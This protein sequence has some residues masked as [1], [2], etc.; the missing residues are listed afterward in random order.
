LLDLPWIA[1]YCFGSSKS[2]IYTNQM[3]LP[4]KFRNIYVSQIFSMKYSTFLTSV[5]TRI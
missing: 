1:F 5:T 4:V 2:V 3:H